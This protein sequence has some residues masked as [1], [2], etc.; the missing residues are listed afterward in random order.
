LLDAAYRYIF[1]NIEYDTEQTDVHTIF[2]NM[3]IIK[4]ADDD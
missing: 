2:K 4:V 3:P 1:N